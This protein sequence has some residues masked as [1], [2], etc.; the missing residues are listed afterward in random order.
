MQLITCANIIVNLDNLTFLAKQLCE[1]YDL[2]IAILGPHMR[3]RAEM[4]DHAE[5]Y[6]HIISFTM[7]H[8]N[9]RFIDLC[10]IKNDFVMMFPIVDFNWSEDAVIM[11]REFGGGVKCITDEMTNQILAQ[12][13]NQILTK[14]KA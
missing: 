8:L 12:Q 13:Y 3:G 14:I 2:C 9:D 10:G 4:F 6:Q 1:S 7:K 11:F 5:M